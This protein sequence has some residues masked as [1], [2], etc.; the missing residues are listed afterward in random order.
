MSKRTH[1]FAWLTTIAAA[2]VTLGVT[3]GCMEPLEAELPDTTPMAVGESR[4]V[5]LRYLRFDVTNFEQVMTKADLLELPQDIQDRLWLLDMDLSNSPS[6]PH[7]LD[8]ALLQIRG[9]D[10]DSLELPARN[11][12]AL[13]NM[14]PDT[15]ELSGTSFEQM[16]ELGPLLGVPAERVLA[17]LTTIP[18][19]AG[20]F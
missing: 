14:T 7:L 6:S 16:L 12:Q 8:N 18:E 2:T 17:D 9:L 3:F 5:E 19:I 15:A 10:P 13:L 20:H 4:V 1:R 11:M